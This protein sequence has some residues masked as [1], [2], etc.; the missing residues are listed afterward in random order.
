MS[1]EITTSEDVITEFSVIIPCSNNEKTLRKS[2]R[3]C[4]GN[5]IF[6]TYHRR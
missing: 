2:I 3:D 4:G 1:V 5:I 6:T